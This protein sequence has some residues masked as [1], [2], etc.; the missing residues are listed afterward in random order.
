MNVDREA[1]LQVFRAETEEGLSQMESSLLRLERQP[2]DQE[3]LNGIFRAVHTLKGDATSLGFG[4]LSE[5]AHGLEDLL[6][7]VRARYV[8]V[9]GGLID[10]LLRA[11]DALRAIL[12][13]ALRGEE[14]L[15]AE[16]LALLNEIS[17]LRRASEPRD[18]EP[19][20]TFGLSPEGPSEATG[21]RTLRVAVDK[22][23]RMLVLAG[24]IA[25]S[26]G[27]V[28]QLM[29]Q[30]ASDGSKE[31]LDLQV[32][33]DRQFLDLQEL[34]M[35]ARLVPLAPLLE[36]LSRVV[37]DA[38]LGAKKLVELEICC[39]GVELDTAVAE[40]VRAPLAHMIRNAVDHGIESPDRRVSLGKAPHGT[41]SIEAR[42]E[43]SSV[44]IQVKDDGAGL[45]RRRIV[46]RA[47]AMSLLREGAR[48]SDREI[49]ELIFAPGFSTASTVT[50]LSGRGV[51]MDVVRRNIDALR[52]SVTIDSQ[53]DRGTTF[54]IRL[55][56]TLTI[57][58]GLVVGAAEERYVIPLS[59]VLECLEFSSVSTDE[60]GV[61]GVANIRGEAVP[62][63]RLR[64]LFGLGDT[65]SPRENIVLL[66]GRE[67]KLGL[68]VDLLVGDAQAVVKPLGHWFRHVRAISGSAILGSGR[69]ALILDV[70]ALLEDVDDGGL[71]A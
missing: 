27:R 12:A 19:A 48:P 64:T 39:D 33:I 31:V 9:R 23:D 7:A 42:R 68:V 70:A 29:E 51:G 34:L 59:S 5:F 16:Q 37:R 22:L 8:S 69:V 32:E 24:E 4:K 49:F 15:G 54:T 56:L 13:A 25:I 10:L 63:L 11:V 53:D 26:R 47:R 17:T 38:A 30:P 40:R 60:A 67:K 21:A 41:I 20:E 14:Q 52:G 58:E 46:E 57:I 50:E 62:Y 61:R 43:G 71:A 55:P 2:E 3:L 36:Q 45:D 65:R 1:L 35:S 28:R 44:V 6:D 18:L 66:R